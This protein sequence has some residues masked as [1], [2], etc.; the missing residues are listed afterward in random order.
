MQLASLMWYSR[1]D[2][3]CTPDSGR[4]SG[5]EVCKFGSCIRKVI[6]TVRRVPQRAST[7]PPCSRTS[8]PLSGAS[9]IAPQPSS[10]H[11]SPSFLS[12]AASSCDR[13]V[14]QNSRRY[15]CI[16]GRCCTLTHTSTRSHANVRVAMRAT[17]A[18]GQTVRHQPANV[19][20]SLTKAGLTL[21]FCSIT[22]SGCTFA[23]G[24]RYVQSFF[25]LCLLVSSMHA[26]PTDRQPRL[27]PVAVR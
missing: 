27:V 21:H 5:W 23:R 13:C 6:V 10:P 15:V 9:A 7:A 22:L 26:R 12:L 4:P 2:C 16:H 3:D 18:G 8:F 20:C 24:T 17:H 14:R 19:S 25:F 11:A 1:V